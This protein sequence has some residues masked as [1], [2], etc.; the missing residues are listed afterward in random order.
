MADTVQLEVSPTLTDADVHAIALLSERVT[1]I[2]GV[3]ALSEDAERHL[4]ATGTGSFLHI[5]AW[6][7]DSLVGYTGLNTSDSLAIP[8]VELVVDRTGRHLGADAML[9]D[10]AVTQSAGSVQIWAHG[11][12]SPAAKLATACGFTKVRRL[13]LMKR[14]L[15]KDLGRVAL[16]PEISIRPF[17]VSR[18]A[19]EWLDLNSRAFAGLP[20]QGRLPRADLDQQLAQEWFDAAG[21][22]LA[23]EVAAD[24][25]QG[26]L[27]GFHWTKIHKRDGTASQ[28][29]EAFGEVY[30]LGVDPGA[31]GRGLG[32][33]LTLAGLK[34]LWS[35]GLSEVI[36]YVEDTNGAAITTYE[37]LG[38]SRFSTDV[39][40]QSGTR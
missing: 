28:H 29:R 19:D 17:E 34:Y 31:Q 5:C 33:A 15:G 39:L 30:V 26:P 22:L 9:L 24:G 13:W 16:P 20:D 1:E 4:L 12:D 3:R 6:N 2:D 21:F 10:Q 25:S 36:L 37:R 38:F 14:A 18:D 32:T 7:G 35:Q 27:V 8:S 40:Y 11:E 23:H